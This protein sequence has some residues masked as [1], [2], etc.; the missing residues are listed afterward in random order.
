MD[1]DPEIIRRGEEESRALRKARIVKTLVKVCSKGKAENIEK[2][3]EYHKN[4]DV[5]QTLNWRENLDSCWPCLIY[6]CRALNLE[7]IKKLLELGADPTFVAK[8]NF[9][10]TWTSILRIIKLKPTFSS[11]QHLIKYMHVLEYSGGLT[12]MM[13]IVKADIKESSEK[14]VS[15][16][17]AL[18]EDGCIHVQS[19][20]KYRNRTLLTYTVM[21]QN[22][23]LLDYF[24]DQGTD[25]NEPDGSG[26]LVRNQIITN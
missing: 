24:L 7:V 5:N 2:F 12:P 4:V 23:D 21:A 19:T 11:T 13:A 20:P 18:V 16:A 8:G 14:S 6:A 22:Q 25:P 1:T 10:V 15:C 26:D 17:K 3:L 9:N